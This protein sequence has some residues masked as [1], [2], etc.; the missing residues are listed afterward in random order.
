MLCDVPHLKSFCLIGLTL[1]I[2]GTVGLSWGYPVFLG[3]VE[4]YRHSK[5]CQIW[6]ETYGISAGPSA[7]LVQSGAAL[8]EEWVG[9][10]AP[11]GVVLNATTVATAHSG[12]PDGSAVN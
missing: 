6:E 10:G 8:A 7:Q 12:V 2:L 1:A 9:R 4:D 5:I 11:A 3:K